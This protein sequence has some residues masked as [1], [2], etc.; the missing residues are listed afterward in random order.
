MYVQLLVRR[1]ECKFGAPGSHGHTR[2][3]DF[4]ILSSVNRQGIGAAI[5]R[6]Y[7]THPGSASPKTEQATTTEYVYEVP[8]RRRCIITLVRRHGSMRVRCILQCMA[9][10]A[11]L[12]RVHSPCAQRRAAAAPV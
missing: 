10:Y 2:N 3:T 7:D 5:H 8:R 11:V 6:G 9:V 12:A 1:R 4:E